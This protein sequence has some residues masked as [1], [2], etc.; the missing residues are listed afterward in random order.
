MTI[1]IQE[2][3]LRSFVGN[4]RYPETAR[5]LG[6]GSPGHTGAEGVYSGRVQ[7]VHVTLVGAMCT[8]VVYGSRAGQQV[9]KA[10]TRALFLPRVHKL[11]TEML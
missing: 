9:H 8:K 4:N 11:H 6:I 5:R 10:C 7:A 2:N 1:F 3:V